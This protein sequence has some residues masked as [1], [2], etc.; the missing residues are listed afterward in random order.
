MSIGMISDPKIFQNEVLHNTVTCYVHENHLL[1]PRVAA[2]LNI[3][4]YDRSGG[5]PSR[6]PGD[7]E[8]VWYKLHLG[9]IWRFWVVLNQTANFCP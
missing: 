9:Q 2:I 6:R 7:F 3:A 1:V 5:R 8:I 4:I